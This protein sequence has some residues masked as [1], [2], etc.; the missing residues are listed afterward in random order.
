VQRIG[1]EIGEKRTEG[2][3]YYALAEA[4]G[5]MGEGELQEEYRN[6]AVKIAGELGIWVE[7]LANV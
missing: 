1:Q 6:K 7:V 2:G 5:E 3:A 4:Y